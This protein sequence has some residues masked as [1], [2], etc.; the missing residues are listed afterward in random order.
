M[1]NWYTT[2]KKED[3]QGLVIDEETGQNIS[4]TYNPKHAALVAAAPRLLQFVNDIERYIKAG[5]IV[6]KSDRQFVLRRCIEAKEG[7]NNEQAEE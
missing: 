1:N 6:T 2:T 7:L 3:L 5:G 4:V